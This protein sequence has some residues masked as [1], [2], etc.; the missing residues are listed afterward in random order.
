MKGSQFFSFHSSHVSNL[1]FLC[2]QLAF[3]ESKEA[4]TTSGKATHR[5][6]KGLRNKVF[7]G[8]HLVLLLMCLLPFGFESWIINFMMS[9][10]NLHLVFSF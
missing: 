9:V 4:D 6:S 2:E 3:E 10:E 7:F 1:R 8:F 5:V